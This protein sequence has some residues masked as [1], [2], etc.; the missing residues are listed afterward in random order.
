MK[1]KGK[2]RNNEKNWKQYKK[3]I[4]N[5]TGKKITKKISNIGNIFHLSISFSKLKLFE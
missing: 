4:S 3:G 5:K 1:S 2:F